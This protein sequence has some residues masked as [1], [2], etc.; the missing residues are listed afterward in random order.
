MKQTLDE[1]GASDWAA[2]KTVSPSERAPDIEAQAIRARLFGSLFGQ[3]RELPRVGRFQILQRLGAGGMGEVF[4]AYDEQLDRRVAIKRLHRELAGSGDHRFEREA[5]GLAKLAHPNVVQVYEVGRDHGQTYIAM[6]FIQGGTL[7]DWQQDR[8]WP[9]ILDAYRQA[10][11]GLCAA[12][13]AGL[14]H[15]DFKPQNAMVQEQ[16]GRVVVKVVDFGLV[17]QAGLGRDVER[18]PRGSLTPEQELHLTRTGRLLGTPAYMAPEQFESATVDAAADQFSLSVSLWEGLYG[19]RPFPGVSSSELVDAVR[20]GRRRSAPPSS[21]VPSWVRN[22]VVRGLA[23]EPAERWPSMR[24]LL[25][26]LTPKPTRHRVW[27]G[28]GAAAAVAAVSLSLSGWLQARTEPCTGG[29]ERLHGVWD[30]QSRTEVKTSILGTGFPFAARVWQDTELALDDY[31]DAWA[32]MYTDACEATTIRGEQSEEVMDLRM[33]CLNDARVDLGAVVEVL[34]SADGQVVEVAGDIVGRL[35]PIARCADVSTLKKD[36]EP[37]PPEVAPV[38]EQARARLVEAYTHLEVSRASLALGKVEAA[39]ALVADVDYGPI[40]TELSL[41]EG[42][43]QNAL[44]NYDDAVV[45][46]Q[47]AEESAAEWKQWPLMGRA[48]RGLMLVVGLGQQKFDV[49][50]QYRPAA[51]GLSKDDPEARAAVHEILGYLNAWQW[52]FEESAAEHRRVLEIRE[53]LYGPDDLRV[54]AVLRDL[55]GALGEVPWAYE[56][57]VGHQRR[58]LAILER[59]LGPDHP[60]VVRTRYALGRMLDHEEGEFHLRAALEGFRNGLGPDTVEVGRAHNALGNLLEAEGRFEEAVEQQTQAA[61][62]LERAMGR[63]H[64]M[65]AHGLTGLGNALARLQR[66]EESIAKHR[67]AMG[68]RVEALGADHP[69]VAQSRHYLG[70]IFHM[71]GRYEEAEAEY[72]KAIEGWSTGSIAM[73][74][75]V[76]MARHNLGLLLA[77]QGRLAEAEA[78]LR[79]AIELWEEHDPGWAAMVRALTN[80]GTVLRRVGKDDEAKAA[81]ARALTYLERELGPSEPSLGLAR[82]NLAA[83]RRGEE[84][85]IELAILLEQWREP[86]PWPA[87]AGPRPEGGAA[88]SPAE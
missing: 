84:P 63:R 70:Q 27:L 6:E 48:L 13:D 67:E 52:R 3:S 35:R 75:D 54:A 21:K 31:G 66:F 8:P 45:A 55:G 18:G 83:V 11:E 57:G 32:T 86:K 78:K 42:H 51:M 1:Q 53:E 62:V 20:S 80:F 10:A 4:S 7:E 64:S 65:R 56:E 81:Y 29:A 72:L 37:P 25:D 33:A 26:A 16:G 77:E 69:E 30:E 28:M 74:R 36:V 88:A 47:R 60:Q 24:A 23:A 41:A 46:F 15:R 79:E 61:A 14:I 9:E 22:A 12:H 85:R 76:S 40:E 68:V 58:A 50:R 87:L 38:V 49:A 71:Q 17:R 2:S 82:D 43:V 39:R 73:S 44:G 5:K 34:A 19:E 59:Q